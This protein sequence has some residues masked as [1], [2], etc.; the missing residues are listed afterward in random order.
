M[1]PMRRDSAIFDVG[2]SEE[3]LDVTSVSI[4]LRNELVKELRERSAVVTY[5]GIMTP[6]AAPSSK[7]VPNAESLAR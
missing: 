5:S 3:V 7:P 1:K 6:R 4:P 2:N